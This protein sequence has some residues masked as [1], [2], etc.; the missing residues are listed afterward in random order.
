MTNEKKIIFFIISIYLIFI[1]KALI[2]KITYNHP[3]LHTVVNIKFCPEYLYNVVCKN[4]KRFLYRNLCCKH[5]GRVQFNAHKTL[6]ANVT[7]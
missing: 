2:G 7:H 4:T 6:T 3:I 5:C 1:V